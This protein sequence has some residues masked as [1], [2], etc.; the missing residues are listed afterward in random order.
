MN[1]PLNKQDRDRKRA[2]IVFQITIYGFLLSMFILQLVWSFQ[3]G[4]WN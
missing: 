3:R 1:A 2:L 4:W